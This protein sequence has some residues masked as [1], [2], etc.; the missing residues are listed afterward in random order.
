MSASIENHSPEVSGLLAAK[1]GF[2][3]VEE[4]FVPTS[5]RVARAAPW[6]ITA[7]CL[8][9]LA[10]AAGIT[11]TGEPPAMTASDEMPAAPEPPVA[12]PQLARASAASAE[13]RVV[14]VKHPRVLPVVLRGQP[15]RVGTGS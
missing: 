8:A 10:A 12:M 2:G 15:P 9:T 5:R 6:L 4:A 1:S 7:F 11:A 14:P 3:V 13:E